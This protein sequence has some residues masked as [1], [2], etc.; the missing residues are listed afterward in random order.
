MA[1]IRFQV[2]NND[3]SPFVGLRVLLQFNNSA[4]TYEATTSTEPVEV[5]CPVFPDHQ[6]DHAG[7]VEVE[8]Y[9]K[10]RITVDAS[11]AFLPHWNFIP[12]DLLGETNLVA[13]H[14]DT[15]SYHV[16][17]TQLDPL[18]LS[19][20]NPYEFLNEA[21]WGSDDDGDSTSLFVTSTDLT[22]AMDSHSGD[23]ANDGANGEY[24]PQ[25]NASS[26][27]LEPSQDVDSDSLSVGRRLPTNDSEGSTGD[28]A[29]HLA[30]R[31]GLRQ[32]GRT[33]KPTRDGVLHQLDRIAKATKGS[34][35]PKRRRNLRTR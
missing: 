8:A 35:R 30:G 32:R 22:P 28:S 3:N 20:A 29:Q 21:L 15:Q 10:Y 4:R 12:I 13:L 23:G 2:F 16:T 14:C 27:V 31:V 19:T 24:E 18:P 34:G 11:N 6:N 25:P 26:R 1:P 9:Q 33:T 7:V 17:L 5:W